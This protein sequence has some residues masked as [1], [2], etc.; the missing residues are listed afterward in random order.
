MWYSYKKKKMTFAQLKDGVKGFFAYAFGKISDTAAKEKAMAFLQGKTVEE[1]ASFCQLWY[2]EKLS[3]KIFQK[4]D[5]EIRLMQKQGKQVLVITAS[6]DFYLAPFQKAYGIT[7]I[8]GTRVDRNE[9]GIFSGHISGNNCRGIEKNLRLAEYLAAKGWQLNTEKSYGYGN[10]ANDEA[11][12]S[13]VK[14]PVLVNPDRKLKKAYPEG[15]RV[16]WKKRVG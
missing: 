3:K 9:Q 11:M 8:I 16:K 13:L 4:A 1:M 6:P 10:S 2:E 12:L 14:H 5:E 7:Q 15:K